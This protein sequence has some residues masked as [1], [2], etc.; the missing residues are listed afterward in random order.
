MNSLQRSMHRQPQ[1]QRG[2]SLIGLILMAVVGVFVAMLATQIVPSVT[3]Y[4]AIERAVNKARN[5]GSDPQTIRASFERAM[6]I[7]NISSISA[8]D[9]KITQR[10]NGYSV[11]FAYE[12]RIPLVGPAYLLLDYKGES[13]PGVGR[14][15]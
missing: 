10:P 11:G 1:L 7:D 2:M 9:L 8:K 13:M 14:K 12:K 15:P 4:I 3:E 6:A 5:D